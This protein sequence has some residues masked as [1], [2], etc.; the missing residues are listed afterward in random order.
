MTKCSSQGHSRA[1]Q[2]SFSLPLHLHPPDDHQDPQDTPVLTHH[3]PGSTESPLTRAAAVGA[4]RARRGVQRGRRGGW[5]G[6]GSGLSSLGAGVPLPAATISGRAR[7]TAEGR[8]CRI[9]D[10][11]SGHTSPAAARP[12]Q[13]APR[14]SAS[15]PPSSH[16]AHVLLSLCFCS[17][18]RRYLQPPE[19]PSSRLS[20]SSRSFQPV[21]PLPS[22][23]LQAVQSYHDVVS[24]GLPS[25]S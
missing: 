15:P 4:A 18:R 10:T 7:M 2:P 8:C 1:P 23:Q 5:H 9:T 14:G 25:P 19:P 16:A 3:G 13:A 11:P 24:C 6:A 17:L 12:P 22:C 20:S 21:P